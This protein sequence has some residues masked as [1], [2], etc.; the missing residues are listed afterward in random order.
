MELCNFTHHAFKHNLMFATLSVRP[1]PFLHGGLVVQRKYQTALGNVQLGTFSVVCI[2]YSVS[3]FISF[4]CIERKWLL[5]LQCP[6]VPGA[7]NT[8]RKA[9]SLTPEVYPQNVR[10]E[11]WW[12]GTGSKY[13]RD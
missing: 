5:L 12:R 10:R 13:A 6:I 8:H 9:G 3:L 4:T 2:N 1:Y 11:G 7:V